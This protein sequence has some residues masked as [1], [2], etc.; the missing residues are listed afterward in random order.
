MTA[1]IG[2]KMFYIGVDTGKNGG[3]AIIRDDEQSV[4]SFVYTEPK[5]REVCD[6]YKDDCKVIVEKVHAMP[7]QGV[8]SMFSFGRSYGYILGVLE[9]SGIN[10]CLVDP[11]R[12][13]WHFRLSSDKSES[14]KLCQKLFPN[15]DLK[16][17]ERCRTPHDGKAEA[18]LIALYGLR[19]DKSKH[20]LK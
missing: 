16:R 11:K 2:A 3:I 5:F 1:R 7:N 19:N 4:Q 8:V 13:K 10:Y 6:T 15:H 17:T 14:I 9:A 20:I 18:L 12:W